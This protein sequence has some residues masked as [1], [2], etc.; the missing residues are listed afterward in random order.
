MNNK[1]A[2]IIT[3]LLFLTGCGAGEKGSEPDLFYD[4]L[5]SPAIITED[6]SRDLVLKSS[7]NV[8]ED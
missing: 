7:A 8:N 5:A 4:G 3:A 6:N 2:Q 1:M